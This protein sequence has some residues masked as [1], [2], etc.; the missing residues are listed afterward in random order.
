MT[1]A[2]LTARNRHGADT[3]VGH[4]CSNL[5][6]QMLAIPSYVRPA[7]ATHPSQTLAA[8]IAWQAARLAE[9]TK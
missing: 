1:N 3:P 4:G 7:W 8:K 9:L 6:E 2:L 5:N